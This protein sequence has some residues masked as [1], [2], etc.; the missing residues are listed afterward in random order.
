M[1]DPR[2]FFALWPEKEV[3]SAFV[4]VQDELRNH[5]RRVA[6][7]NLHLTLFFLGTIK[8]HQLGQVQVL[9]DG[10][11]GNSFD[12]VFKQLGYWK[13]P[14]VIWAGTQSVPQAL[15]HLVNQLGS[16]LADMGFA[17]ELRPYV[18]HLTLVRKVT[19]RPKLPEFHPISWAIDSFCL[20]QSRLSST[21]ANYQILKSWP[22]R[23]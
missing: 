10:I 19:K 12:L 23:G 17:K 8:V 5:G 2:L 22:L 11:Q 13:K 7:Q 6:P 1:S 18:P 21:G 4:D 14:Q 3:V 20:V 16:G 9:A 15:E